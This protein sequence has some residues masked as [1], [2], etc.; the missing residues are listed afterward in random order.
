MSQSLR[1]GPVT[2]APPPA[3]RASGWPAE[4]RSCG[5]SVQPQ[6][7][8]L[9]GEAPPSPCCWPCTRRPRGGRHRGSAAGGGLLSR[10]EAGC[11]R[12]EP[13]GRVGPRPPWG[14]PVPND[15]QTHL[16]RG[17]GRCRGLRATGWLS[18]RRVRLC[19]CTA[20]GG[21]R[22]P[23][24]CG[25]FWGSG[26]STEEGWGRSKGVREGGPARPQP[27][28][29][30]R[31]TEGG[32]EAP[33]QRKKEERSCCSQRGR[34]LQDLGAREALKISRT[35]ITATRTLILQGK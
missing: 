29:T 16:E 33:K 30:Q 26:R 6:G 3:A 1:P 11:G 17:A 7:P 23:Q 34:K 24:N 35:V 31:L 22:A 21:P 32:P 20:A 13:G 12:T 9:W 27:H 15:A 18:P 28:S 19:V 5:V 10:G 14:A 25:L 8:P 2:E 4:S